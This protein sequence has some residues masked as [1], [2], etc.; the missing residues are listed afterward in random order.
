MPTPLPDVQIPSEVPIATHS[1]S[2]Y[3]KGFE[4]IPAVRDI[5]GPETGK[6]LS[7]LR[8]EF[9]SSKFGYMGVSDEDGHLI[10]SAYYLR[11]GEPA[12]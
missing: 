6:V 1:F 4:K 5:F 2:E 11:N 3:F 8:V 10:V 12:K 7:E 9:F